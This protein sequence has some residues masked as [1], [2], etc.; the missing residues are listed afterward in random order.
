[1][2][3]SFDRAASTYDQ[4]AVLQREVCTRALER[5]DLV[6]LDPD[7]IIDAGCGTGFASSALHKRFPRATLV[8]LDIAPTMLHRSRSRVPGWK[9]WIGSSREVFVCGDNERLPIRTACV[10]MLWSNLSFQWAG[11]LT[12]VFAECQRVLRPGGLLM[13]TTFGPDTLKELRAACAGDG[14]IHV[15]RFIDMHDIGD[16]MIGAGFAD[17]VMDM[18]YLTLTYADVCT[19]MRELKAIGAHNVA[20]GRDRGLTGKRALK[21]IELR[22]ESF[23]QDTRLPAT[24]E[25]IYGHAWKPQP[26]KLADGRAIIKTDFKL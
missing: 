2:R 23:R 11:D 12:T 15:N 4:A 18:E 1:M 3:R 26:K 6:R 17:P 8:E 13:F 16:M 21:E 20:A 22:Y 10:D 7:A 19:L 24:F 5:L 14:K 25:V 9:R